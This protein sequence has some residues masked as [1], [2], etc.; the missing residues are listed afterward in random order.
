MGKIKT[1][2]RYKGIECKKREVGQ[3]RARAEKEGGGVW[4]WLVG[5]EVS[6]FLEK[7][8]CIVKKGVKNCPEK[9]MS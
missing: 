7:G 1:G 4:V 3:K 5:A 2:K 6:I 9:K 8:H